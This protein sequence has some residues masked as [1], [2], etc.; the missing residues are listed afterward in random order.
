MKA[1]IMAILF[2]IFFAPQAQAHPHVFITPKAVVTMNNHVVS[3]IN[4]EWDFD[5]MSSAM[6]SESVGSNTDEIWNLV[7]PPSQVLAD[8]SQAVRSGYYTNIEIDGTPIANLTPVDFKATFVN[9]GLH[10]N[11]TIIINQNVDH[12]VKI[13]FDDSTIYN[14]FD[15]QRGNFQVSDQ[16]GTSHVL[17]KQTEKDIDK[18]LLSY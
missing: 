4:V 16:S 7:F 10:C 5:D 13:W 3:Q 18:I 11:F 14:A 6:F 2:I 9:G 8:G 1:W 12:T 15:V 17:Q